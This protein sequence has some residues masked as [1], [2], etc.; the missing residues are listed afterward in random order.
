MS[1]ANVGAIAM[2]LLSQP[3]SLLSELGS[4]QSTSSSSGAGASTRFR[5]RLSCRPVCKLASELIKLNPVLPTGASERHHLS[6]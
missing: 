2:G 6:R 1:L 3:L 4:S 5:P